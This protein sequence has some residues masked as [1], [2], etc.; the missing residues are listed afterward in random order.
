MSTPDSSSLLT[1]SDTLQ[2]L[3]EEEAQ[4]ADSAGNASETII[5]IT[6]NL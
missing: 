2:L 5:K 4:A 1:H 3:S 6:P